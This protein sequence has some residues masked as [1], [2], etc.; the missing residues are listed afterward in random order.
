MIWVPSH[1][2]S[3]SFIFFTYYLYNICIYTYTYTYIYIYIY[4][5]IYIFTY[6]YIY[7]HIQ[8]ATQLVV[9]VYIYIYI[10]IKCKELQIE[11]P[12]YL[13]IVSSPWRFVTRPSS[14][15]LRDPCCSSWWIA[16]ASRCWVPGVSP[17]RKMGEM[18]GRTMEWF[19]GFMY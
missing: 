7:I 6:I 9:G 17:F 14:K 16:M 12:N 15:D 2:P 5:Y 13:L 18:H 8:T 1:L 10:R 19:Q 3:F 4:T 11:F